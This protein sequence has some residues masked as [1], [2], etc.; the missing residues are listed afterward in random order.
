V[1]K[2][3]IQR[4]F[5]VA[6]GILRQT[7]LAAAVVLAI[8]IPGSALA[9]PV[10]GPNGNYYELI[11]TALTWT[12]AQ[13]AAQGTSFMGEQGYLATITS[14]AENA[15]VSGLLN[16]DNAWLGGSDAGVPDT[17]VWADGP[18]SGDAFWQGGVGG[19][20]V[21]GAYTN[22]GSND[23]N[24]GLVQDSVVMCAQNVSPCLNENLGQWIDRQASDSHNYVIEYATAIPE[25]STGVL[26][27]LGLTA[28]AARR[29]RA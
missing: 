15:F 29:R 2:H 25:P 16:G 4:R 12:E 20:P 19:S 24:G 13:T 10:L 22:W 7:G 14:A 18:E 1:P 9:V 28:I 27:G 3:S 8:G 17:W 5:E 26:V 21:G 23:P 11:E 6:R